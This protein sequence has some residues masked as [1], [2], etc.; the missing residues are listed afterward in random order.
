M[1][2]ALL[3]ALVVPV[4][5]PEEEGVPLALG[6]NEEG[7]L[8]EALG[9]ALKDE[10]GELEEVTVAD[11][12]GEPLAVMEV[13]GVAVPEAVPEAP[14]DTVNSAVAL[15]VA[16]AEEVEASLFVAIEE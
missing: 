10:E 6:D 12:A 4:A 5:L 9:V 2:A 7:T 1:F 3:V 8:G 13:L 11:V 16:L 15:A 14:G